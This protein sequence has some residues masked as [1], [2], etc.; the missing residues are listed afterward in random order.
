LG[1]SSVQ[2]DAAEEDRVEPLAP[3]AAPEDR[4]QEPVWPAARLGE[5]FGPHGGSGEPA[6]Q[7]P[8]AAPD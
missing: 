1:A 3:A 4:P 6:P 5:S 7:Q 2:A 8:V